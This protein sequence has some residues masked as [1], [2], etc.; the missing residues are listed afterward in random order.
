M[1]LRMHIRSTGKVTSGTLKVRGTSDA[2]TDVTLNNLYVW[3]EDE[4]TGIGGKGYPNVQAHITIWRM[5][6]TITR[7]GNASSPRPDD[8]IVVGSNTYMIQVV[9][10][11]RNADE[12]STK[13]AVYQC[14]CTRN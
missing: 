4:F 9:G 1:D 8:K 11:E 2:F 10:T 14:T 5:G 13:F 6:E 12:S 7:G 3:P